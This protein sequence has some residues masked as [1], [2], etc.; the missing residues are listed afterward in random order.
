MSW[1]RFFLTFVVV[2]VAVT[3]LG[4][5]IH[6]VLLAS[7]YQKVSHLH[8]SQP[9]FPFLL[10]GNLSF[11]LAFVWLYAKGVEAKPWLGQGL[12]FGLAIWL[13]WA[14]AI[15]LIQYAGQPLPGSL[16]GKQIG[17]EFFDMLA[18]GALTAALYRQ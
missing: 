15:F 10:L 13:L 11:S 18:L 12:R 16:I 17:L 4:Y 1:K 6:A 5:F 2:F 8:R 14:V 7:E 9:L 3:V